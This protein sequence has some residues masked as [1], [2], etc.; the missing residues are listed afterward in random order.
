VD[1]RGFRWAAACG[2]GLVHAQAIGGGEED[3]S[4][5]EYEEGELAGAR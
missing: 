3:E 2:P 1:T 4:S 5:E